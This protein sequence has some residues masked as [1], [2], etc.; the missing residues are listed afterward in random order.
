MNRKLVEGSKN[1]HTGSTDMNEKS[2]RSHC[3]FMIRVEQEEII[4][5]ESKIRAGK[6]NLVDLAGSERQKKTQATGNRSK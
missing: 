3:I 1:R 6:L 2:S 5:G 4:K